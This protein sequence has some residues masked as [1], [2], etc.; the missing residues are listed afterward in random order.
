[1][2]SPVYLLL[3]V[4]TSCAVKPTSSHYDYKKAV[5]HYYCISSQGIDINECDAFYADF[6][7]MFT[8]RSLTDNHRLRKREKGIYKFE[9][10]SPHAT[11]HLLYIDKASCK[12]IPVYGDLKR[13]LKFNR[14]FMKRNKSGL[15][16]IESCE[17]EIVNIY[18]R[19]SRIISAQSI[20]TLK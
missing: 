19:N 1:M 9:M 14:Q 11:T 12:V 8:V 10:N 5:A 17:K 3:F 6:E 15:K 20:E 13:I 18:N 7:K 2:K 16:E 4:L